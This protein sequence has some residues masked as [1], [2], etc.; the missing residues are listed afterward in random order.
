MLQARRDERPHMSA[1]YRVRLTLLRRVL[2]LASALA[3][4]AGFAACD[5]NIDLT[6]GLYALIETS[7]GDILLSLEYE[8]VPMTVANFVGLA[9]GTIES[10][11]ESGK[12]YYDGLTFHR[13]VDGFVIQGGDPAGDGTGGPGYSFPDEF[14]P[15][16]R[17]SKAG[18][19]SMANSGADTNGSQFFITLAATPHLDDKHS[20]LGH[21]VQGDDV[22]RKI[23]QGDKM[24]RVRIIRVGDGAAAFDASQAAFDRLVS[25]AAARAEER[26]IERRESDL[27]LIAER[28][29]QGVVT[30]TGIRY[31]IEKPGTG[32]AKPKHGSSVTVHY[33]GRLL[34]G[35]EFDNSRTRGNPTTFKIGQVIEGWNQSLTDMTKGESRL[36]VIPPE[37]GYGS[38]GYPGVIPPESF[39]VFEVELIDFQ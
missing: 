24:R 22:V 20:V 6:D 15:T 32:G 2:L 25:T 35:T 31:V 12:P 9:E 18:I 1:R 7:K 5:K 27:A 19:L 34:D 30:E 23:R 8:K 16:L 10:A 11:L 29:P 14:D 33:V 3:L 26:K 13:V 4:V 28:W 17:H 37:L 38:R 36:I 21:V 39:L